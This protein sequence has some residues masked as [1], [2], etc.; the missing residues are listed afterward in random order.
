MFFNGRRILTAQW[1]HLAMLNYAIDAD[2]LSSY[3]PNGTELE[4]WKGE[5]I[6]SVVGFLF[7]D[8][9]LFGLPI[10]LH[11]KF[12][13]INLRFYV[14]RKVGTEWRRGVVFVKELAPRRAVAWLANAL[15]G[16]RYEVVSMSHCIESDGDGSHAM[17]RVSYSWKNHVCEGVLRA[18]A[19]GAAQR[20]AGDSIE[21]FITE[22]YWGYTRLRD[23]STLEYRVEHPPWSIW[24]V[25]DAVFTCDAASV[26]GRPFAEALTSKPVSAFL[27]DGSPVTVY[28]AARI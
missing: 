23:G 7:L 3:V 4:S 25:R 26:Y 1:R 11:R 22:N 19:C 8:A 20:A 17:P 6:V 18:H 28:G 27:V 16:E 24:P 5:A 2:A 12:E 14:R 15:Y 13:E 9:R 10:P 21:A